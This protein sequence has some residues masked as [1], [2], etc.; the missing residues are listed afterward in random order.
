MIQIVLKESPG[1]VNIKASGHSLF[2]DKGKDLVCC[3]VSTLI[4]SWHISTRELCKAGVTADK[5]SG[6]FEARAEKNKDSALLFNSLKLSLSVI[7]NRY[8]DNIKLIV[9]DKNGT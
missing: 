1:F 9:E 5:K 6:Y 3:A 7:A 2:D 8:P 4:Q